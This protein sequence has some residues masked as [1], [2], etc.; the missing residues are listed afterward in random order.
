MTTERTCQYVKKLDREGDRALE[1]AAQR[2]CGVSFPGV[3]Q[4][5]P[6]HHPRQP[7]VGTL[8]GGW[9]SEVPSNLNHCITL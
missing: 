3:I 6:G 1:W 5:P 2:E 7:A 8:Q 9:T 4:K